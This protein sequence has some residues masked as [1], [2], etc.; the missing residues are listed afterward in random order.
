MPAVR[1]RLRG[2]LRDRANEWQQLPPLDDAPRAAKAL[3]DAAARSAAED[4][5]SA[6]RSARRILAQTHDADPAMPRQTA[7]DLLET[8]RTVA[9]VLLEAAGQVAS[10]LLESTRQAAVMQELTAREELLRAVLDTSPAITV[11]AGLDGRIEYV[12]R[13]TVEVSGRRCCVRRT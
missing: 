7:L 8:A 12:N 11:R 6:E 3:V 1:R 10:D 5:A 2:F 9:S 13:R 4:L